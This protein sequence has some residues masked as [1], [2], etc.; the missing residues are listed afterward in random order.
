[1]KRIF[2]LLA[3]APLLAGCM[4]TL[5]GSVAGSCPV[6]E[7]PPYAVKGKTQYDQNVADNF[8][9]SGVA[10]CNWAR[11]AARPASLDAL[12]AHQATKAKRGLLRRIKDRA[13]HPFTSHVAP[14]L[15]SP[16]V[17]DL[18]LPPMIEP[19]KPRDP[20]DELLHPEGG[21]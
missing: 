16:P 9:E 2:I 19:P 10:G 18:T 13:E 7:R 14:V 1:V 3:L 12:T 4:Q 15:Q 8:V 17:P 11:P 6:F 5:N 21:K 20:V